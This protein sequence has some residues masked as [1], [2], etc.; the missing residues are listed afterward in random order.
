MLQLSEICKM[1]EDSTRAA[2]LVERT[3]YALEAAFHP[4]FNLAVCFWQKFALF[5]TKKEIHILILK[6]F[7]SRSEPQDSITRG[8]KIG[9]FSLRFFAT[10]PMWAPE[11]VTVLHWNSANLLSG[12]YLTHYSPLIQPSFTPSK[13][14]ISTWTT[15]IFFWNP[16]MRKKG[17]F[18]YWICN[19]VQKSS[20]LWSKKNYLKMA[21]AW[22]NFK[23]I[24]SRPLFTIIFRPEMLKFHP[25]SILT[26]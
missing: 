10:F 24:F 1:G 23:N 15:K 9:L 26:G 19:F 17:H 7:L 6:L 12:K 18:Y 16:S 5:F 21:C 22:R 2:E 8:K 20:F 11:P 4:L 25:Y 3:L 13:C 14:I